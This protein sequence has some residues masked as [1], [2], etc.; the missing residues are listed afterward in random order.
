MPPL[1]PEYM[2]RP[3]EVVVISTPSSWWEPAAALMGP[4]SG[5]LGVVAGALITHKLGKSQERKR[6]KLEKLLELTSRSRAL[7]DD[8][9]R[10]I[11]S[12]KKAVV[13][14]GSSYHVDVQAFPNP[15]PINADIKALEF[16][17]KV[18][19]PELYSES[20]AFVRE[21]IGLCTEI[22]L[23]A[24]NSVSCVDSYKAF[25]LGLTKTRSRASVA[26]RHLE[27]MAIKEAQKLSNR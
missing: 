26:Q 17:V 8:S 12:Y 24:F 20:E 23:E 4:I 2:T 5:L 1:L 14:S 25:L 16:L 7:Y 21:V 27:S 18:H 13:I 10:F 3:L 15:D 9:A 22:V 6:L 11:E 19:C